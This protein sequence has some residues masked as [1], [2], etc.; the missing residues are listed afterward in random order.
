MVDKK[1]V[2]CVVACPLLEDE[3]IHS[4]HE[5]TQEKKIYIADTK[6]SVSIKRKM[7]AK[8]MK[9]DLITEKD[10]FFNRNFIDKE[11]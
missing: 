5:D 7:D 1:G 6:P 10:F 2:M 3:L 9:Y 4:L 11:K 8:G